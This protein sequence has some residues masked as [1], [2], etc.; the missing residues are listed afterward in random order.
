MGIN[1]ATVVPGQ[2][3]HSCRSPANLDAAN[4]ACITDIRCLSE[5]EGH[6]ATV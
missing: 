1:P 3:A 2:T 6:P 5:K 4:A